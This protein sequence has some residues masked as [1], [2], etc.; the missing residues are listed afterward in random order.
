MDKRHASGTSGDMLLPGERCASN[1]EAAAL[2]RS[3]RENR[4]Q[5]GGG[6]SE[7]RGAQE[8]E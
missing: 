2:A 1:Y 5:G 3:G 6:G 8:E 4:P 7:M